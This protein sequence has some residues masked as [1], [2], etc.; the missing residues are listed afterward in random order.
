VDALVNRK[1]LIQSR[2]MRMSA[3]VAKR[4]DGAIAD[5]IYL[6]ETVTASGTGA[7]MTGDERMRKAHL[8]V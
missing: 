4:A 5:K 2:A 3:E 8:G 7:A 6:L 1:V